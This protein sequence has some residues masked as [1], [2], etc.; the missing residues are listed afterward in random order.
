MVITTQIITCTFT[1]SH[2]FVQIVMSY[3]LWPHGLQHARLPCPS[4]SPRVCSNSCPLSWWCHPT[5]SSS[6]ASFSCPQSFPTSGSF[7]V[8]WFFA[9]GGQSIGASASTSILPKYIQ[10]WFTLKLTSVISLVSNNSQES[11]PTPR[12]KSINSSV[13]S[14]LYGPTLIS[15]HDYRKEMS[16]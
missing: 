8:T 15:V 13:L 11:F 10:D 14:L 12:F 7:P 3:S 2:I 16:T 4:L 6:V 5:I 9:S 1:E